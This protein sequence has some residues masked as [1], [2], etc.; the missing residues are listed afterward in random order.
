MNNKKIVIIAGPNGAGKTTFAK[1]YLPDYIKMNVFV[2]AD[3]IAS[4]LSP[5]D[6]PKEALKAGKIMLGILREKALKGEN[7]AFESTLSGKHYASL[8]PEWQKK[9]YYVKLFYLSLPEVFFAVKRVEQRVKEGGHSIPED[10]IIRRYKKSL[11]NFENIYK[12]IVD[13][14]AVYDNSG[15]EPMLVSEGKNNEN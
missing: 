4:G 12:H 3:L 9:G 1:V 11:Y 2:N 8:I 10:V 15:S 5:F 6:P 7:F 13:E 14:W